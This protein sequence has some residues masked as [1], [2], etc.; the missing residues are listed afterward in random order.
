M[1]CE[2]FQQLAEGVQC[3]RV[4]AR[5]VQ[6]RSD[7]EGEPSRVIDGPGGIGGRRSTSRFKHTELGP[8]AQLMRGDGRGRGGGQ[9]VAGS[10][11]RQ[12]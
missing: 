9:R 7:K 12:A 5:R 2:A 4:R 8:I 3:G 10:L 11:R 1:H 6:P